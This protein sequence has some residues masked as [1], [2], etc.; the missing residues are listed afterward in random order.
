M[1][2]GF[3]ALLN[4]QRFKGMPVTWNAH[5]ASYVTGLTGVAHKFLTHPLGHTKIEGVSGLPFIAASSV[6]LSFNR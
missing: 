4:E 5:A 2:L 6:R 3:A 1:Y